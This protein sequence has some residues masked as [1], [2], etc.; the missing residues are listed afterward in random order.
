MKK[1]FGNEFGKGSRFPGPMP[2][3]GASAAAM[4]EGGSMG[5]G[6]ASF[7]QSEPNYVV[8][9]LKFNGKT[10]N[11]V[12]FRLKGNSTLMMSW[13]QGIYKLPFRLS[14][15]EFAPKG[16]AKPSFY[17]FHELSI[18]LPPTTLHFYT[19]K[20]PLIYSVKQAFPPPK[21]LFIAYLS[22]LEKA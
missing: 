20:W 5:G 11:S 1:K 3:N 2:R 19:K 7:G 14:F 21:R 4:R 18:H 12:G 16:A 9:S 6:P 8:A 15:D 22:I 17:G 10:W 13:G